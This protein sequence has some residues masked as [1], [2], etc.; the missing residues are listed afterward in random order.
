MPNRD[1]TGPDGN[2]AT[3]RR[4]GGCTTDPKTGK[5]VCPM[6]KQKSQGQGQGMGRGMRRG[7]GGRG[8]GQ[9]KS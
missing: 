8:Q 6:P 9:N 1:G 4:M 3:G 5:T 7:R 2:G